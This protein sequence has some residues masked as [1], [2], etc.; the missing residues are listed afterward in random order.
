M[1]C[2]CCPACAPGSSSVSSSPKSKGKVAPPK[3]LIAATLQQTGLSSQEQHSTSETA[4]MEQLSTASSSVRPVRLAEPPFSADLSVPLGSN[5]R[6]LYNSAC[7]PRRRRLPRLS[8][9][10]SSS[11][12]PLE[13][14]VFALL[15]TKPRMG[16]GRALQHHQHMMA[17]EH[18]SHCPNLCSQLWTPVTQQPCLACPADLLCCS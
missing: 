9:E 7:K 17:I 3:G 16:M 8:I 18:P 6:H 15:A 13:D 10:V 5:S 1:L 14:A 4:P 12:L 11:W 2:L